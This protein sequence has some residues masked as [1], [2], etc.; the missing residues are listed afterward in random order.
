VLDVSGNKFYTQY[1]KLHIYYTC[2]EWTGGIQARSPR[3]RPVILTN[4]KDE[5]VSAGFD[6][7][8]MNEIDSLKRKI[9]ASLV[10]FLIILAESYKEYK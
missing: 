7:T 1:R 8:G 2:T 4:A 6:Y 10:G 3:V 9:P 5:V